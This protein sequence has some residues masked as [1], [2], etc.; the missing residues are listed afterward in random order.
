M[1]LLPTISSTTQAPRLLRNVG[2]TF[3]EVPCTLPPQLDLV[4]WGD[5]DND[6]DPDLVAAY[7]S[8]YPSGTVDPYLAT[9]FRNDDGAFTRADTGLPWILAHQADF[10]DLDN[11][12]DLDL[13][14]S[15]ETGWNQTGRFMGR[16]TC[17]RSNT[18]P[19]AP[20]SLSV[21]W[22][23]EVAVLQWAPAADTE[24]GTALTYNVRIGTTPGGSEVMSAAADPATG[25]RRLTG[26]GSIGFAPRWR[27]VPPDGTYYWSVQ[28]VDAGYAASPF[29]PESTFTY[30]HPTIS[31]LTNM[32]RYPG[33]SPAVQP[34]TVGDTDSDA[35]SLTLSA[36]CSNP[37]L[38]PLANITFSGSGSNR[39]VTVQPAPGAGG[40]AF[41]SVIV[42]DV[43]GLNAT[44]TFRFEVAYFTDL[45]A[46]IPGAANGTPSLADFDGDGDLDLYLA[47]TIYR[48]DG[49]PDFHCSVRGQR[50]AAARRDLG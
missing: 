26:I 7:G 48:N 38:V 10:A 15:G 50:W 30:Y 41:I 44:N 33:A 17:T 1:L 14:F 36:Q 23:G 46:T 25:Q 16:N 49:R 11:D 29:A 20:M 31:T 12:G 47:G 22:G 8:D 45:A 13:L 6:G 39:T 2:G 34:V 4:S 40:V 19:P 37:T 28:S 35:G 18:P 24:S 3:V 43:T 9:V 42:S 27:L 5:F 32:V 21:G